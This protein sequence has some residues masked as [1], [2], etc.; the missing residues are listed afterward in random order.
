M[1]GRCIRFCQESP[2]TCLATQNH[3]ADKRNQQT[4]SLLFPPTAIHPPAWPALPRAHLLDSCTRTPLSFYLGQLTPSIFRFCQSLDHIQPISMMQKDYRSIKLLGEGAF[5]Q[6]YLM[7][8]VPTQ[9]L[10]CVKAC[11]EGNDGPVPWREVN[12]MKTLCHPC[13][14][15]YRDNFGTGGMLYIVMQYADKGDL[16]FKLKAARRSTPRMHFPETQIWH[17][18]SQLCLALEYMHARKIIHRDIKPPNIFLLGPDE[19]LVL[20]DV[21]VAKSLDTTKAFAHTGIG[22]PYYMAPEIFANKGHNTKADVWSLGVL[23]YELAYLRQAF[24]GE[25]V[26]E[27]GNKV[28]SGRFHPVASEDT[29]RYS[30]AL[31]DVLIELLNVNPN[32]CPPVA[33]FLQTRPAIMRRAQEWS[34]QMLSAA[35]DPDTEKG[36]DVSAEQQL[37]LQR[38]MEMLWPAAAF[39]A[40][41]PSVS[42][43]SSS[44]PTLSLP[45]SSSASS[46]SFLSYSMSS[47]PGQPHPSVSSSA[48]TAA[49]VDVTRH[50]VEVQESDLQQVLE[51]LRKERSARLESSLTTLSISDVPLMSQEEPETDEREERWEEQKEGDVGGISTSG[52]LPTSVAETSSD[53]F[54]LA[55]AARCKQQHV[56]FF[57]S[58]ER[59][60]AVSSSSDGSRPTTSRMT[61]TMNTQEQQEQQHQQQQQIMMMT[62]G[63]RIQESR[64]FLIRVLGKEVFEEVHSRSWKREER[65]EVSESLFVGDKAKYF[66]LFQQLLAMEAAQRGDTSLLLDSV[67]TRGRGSG[68]SARA[69]GG[70]P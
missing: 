11:K 57:K 64:G 55:S 21:G 37:A 66:G 39:A 68:V 49:A 19:R 6:V 53:L 17:W 56:H 10:V 40:S 5:G 18:F 24:D 28:L 44:Y 14:V 3:A 63:G 36:V 50:S 31:G 42:S 47:S 29:H 60:R 8:H 9:Q 23:L 12:I 2:G 51:K 27:I 30:S 38:Q 35:V 33:D 52:W 41:V 67:G 34:R 65:E 54:P 59:K 26:Q 62:M 20:G 13:I 1:P 32:R 46:S 45:S 69:E 25:S 4:A 16:S 70:E 22:T 7:R 15:R 43:S 48:A 58:Q 61:S